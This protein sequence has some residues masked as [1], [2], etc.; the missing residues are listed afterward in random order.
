MQ[1]F[2]VRSPHPTIQGEKTMPSSTSSRRIP[3]AGG[4]L[5]LPLAAG[6]LWAGLALALPTPSAQAALILEYNFNAGSGTSA[7]DSSGFGTAAPGTLTGNATWSTNTPSGS[8]YSL[9]L[10][11]AIADTV[12]AGDV[13]KLDGLQ[14]FTLV[15]WFNP[16]SITTFDRLMSKADTNSGFD[17]SVTVTTNPSNYRLDLNLKGAGA[18]ANYYSTANITQAG[19]VF[20]AV[21]Y[22]GSVTTNN[23]NYYWG[24]ASSG[25]AQLGNTLSAAQGTIT[26]TTGAFEIGDTDRST[27]DR[28]PNALF[29]N[30]RIY[31][32]V[33]S[34][35]SLETLR[36]ADIPEPG[37]AMLTAIGALAL[38]RRRRKNG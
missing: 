22:D 35:S 8:G 38:L 1:S 2:A 24:S 14:K 16:T 29:D 33:E 30:V 31:N 28:S 6:A 20:L 9:S 11:G 25:V 27:S 19:W 13:S 23:L 26:D 5:S 36:V 21:T 4:S 7:A 3:V 15:T 12:N 37:T 10:P 32:T 17:W 34:V 18:Q